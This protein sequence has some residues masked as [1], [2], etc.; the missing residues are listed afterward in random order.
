MIKVSIYIKDAWQ[1]F[2]EPNNISLKKQRQ[3]LL[4]TKVEIHKPIILVGI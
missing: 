4:Q 1:T 3:K 2:F